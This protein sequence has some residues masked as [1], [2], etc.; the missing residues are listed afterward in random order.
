MFL[1]VFND[2]SLVALLLHTKCLFSLENDVYCWKMVHVSVCVAGVTTGLDFLAHSL[3]SLR[4]SEMAAGSNYHGAL[5][6]TS[7]HDENIISWVPLWC[8]VLDSRPWMACSRDISF[9]LGSERLIGRNPSLLILSFRHFWVICTLMICLVARLQ[10]IWV[11]SCC[12]SQKRT[13]HTA[14]VRLSLSH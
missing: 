11:S 2:L 3:F 7:G 12:S 13:F 5:P 8:P 6:S 9:L 4:C 10:W 1:D 14:P